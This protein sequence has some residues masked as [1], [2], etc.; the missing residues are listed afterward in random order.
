MLYNHALMFKKK[1]VQAHHH[2]C[3]TILYKYTSYLHA[4][5]FC[6][7]VTLVHIIEPY[8]TNMHYRK[9][10]AKTP[11]QKVLTNHR[12]NACQML[13]FFKKKKSELTDNIINAI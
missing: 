9:N 3:T 10:F 2:K 12:V 8:C 13:P 11:L 6:T 7:L 5:V 4:Q 1:Q